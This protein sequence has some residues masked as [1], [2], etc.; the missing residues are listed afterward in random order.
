MTVTKSLCPWST[1][2]TPTNRGSPG[3]IAPP[4]RARCVEKKK[5]HTERL[6]TKNDEVI[7]RKKVGD[8]RV[9]FTAIE[10]VEKAYTVGTKPLS[11]ISWPQNGRAARRL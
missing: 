10:N 8:K 4:R 6:N 1:V 7:P 2:A 9:P 11:L 5:I 3:L